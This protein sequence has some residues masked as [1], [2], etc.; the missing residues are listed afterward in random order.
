MAVVSTFSLDQETTD[1]LENM[2][3]DSK[4]GKSEM[5]RWLIRQE[6]ERRFGVNSM[7]SSKE[8]QPQPEQ[9]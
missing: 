7:E 5:V 2:S 9:G 6:Y 8:Q 1:M 3:Q 4:T